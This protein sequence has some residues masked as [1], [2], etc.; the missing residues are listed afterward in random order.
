MA[1]VSNTSTLDNLRYVWIETEPNN[2]EIQAT[3]T[4]A[5]SWK[6][7]SGGKH[8]V[9]ASFFGNIMTAFHINNGVS[10]RNDGLLNYDDYDRKARPLAAM[11]YLKKVVNGSNFLFLD[12][13]GK[14]PFTVI[15]DVAQK[16]IQW[17][18]G[19]YDLLL[20]NT[21]AES[22]YNSAFNAN[23]PSYAHQANTSKRP[24]TAIGIKSN[25]NIVLAAI[26]ENSITPT[27]ND[28]SQPVDDG[29][30]G[31][32]IFQIKRLMKDFLLCNRALM[33][34]GGGSTQVSY[35]PAGISA[36]RSIIVT[37]SGRVPLCRIVAK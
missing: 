34:D 37:T 35:K 21:Q 9:N 12:K 1:T 5:N 36:F 19:G 28:G 25:G 13:Q 32:T 33:I 20:S 3:D 11:A 26:F 24:R 4:K 29:T 22:G 8:A 15:A 7:E 23:Y 16:D 2:I 18:I 6:A 30:K 17:A 27:S 14:L 31:A 10:V